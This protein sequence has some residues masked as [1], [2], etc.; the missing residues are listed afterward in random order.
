MGL[1]QA[2]VAELASI[3]LPSLKQIE[4]GK[5]NVGLT[6]LLRL[7]STLGLQLLLDKRLSNEDKTR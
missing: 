2:Y 3:S 5:T 7:L 6:P 1:T 4:A